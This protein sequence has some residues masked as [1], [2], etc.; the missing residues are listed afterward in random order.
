MDDTSPLPPLQPPRVPPV[1]PELLGSA[2]FLFAE[3]LQRLADDAIIDN[4]EDDDDLD[5]DEDEGAS[6]VNMRDVLDLFAE[7]LGT[8]VP[9]TLNLYMRVTALFRLLAASPSLARL[10]A[11][12]DES[13]NTLSETALVA[14]ARLDLHVNR[15]EGGGVADF[16]P[17]QFR[18]ALAA[19]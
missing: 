16:D 2:T 19:G 15:S 13:A 18:E 12:N 14:A 11:D 1:E 3:Y 7:E 9:I 5:D 4:G 10:A 6:A 8:S 17:R